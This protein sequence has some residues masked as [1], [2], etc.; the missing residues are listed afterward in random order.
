VE[1]CNRFGCFVSP[2]LR[3]G[4]S[5][6]FNCGF[7][8]N[9]EEKEKLLCNSKDVIY[10]F[11]C[12]TCHGEYIGETQSIRN[13]LSTHCSQIRTNQHFCRATDHLIECGSQ[14]SDVR[15][16]FSVFLLE[17]EHD[18]NIRKAKESFYI[19]LFKPLMNK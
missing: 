7:V 12:K 9:V 11:I 3:N 14:L 16:R 5:Y 17:T 2:Q 18:T 1:K 15:E 8:F 4:S 19:R 13:R 10:V 6:R